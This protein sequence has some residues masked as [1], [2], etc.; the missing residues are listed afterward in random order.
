LSM[1]FCIHIGGFWFALHRL[2]AGP[3]AV[4][5]CYVKIWF[6]QMQWWVS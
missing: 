1:Q 6:T 2:N 3:S 5:A 4:P